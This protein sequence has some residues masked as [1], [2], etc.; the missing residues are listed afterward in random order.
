MR[1]RR[2]CGHGS[3]KQCDGVRILRTF[4]FQYKHI[5][6]FVIQWNPCCILKSYIDS[7]NIEYIEQA[8]RWGLVAVYYIFF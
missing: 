5:Q 7:T 6:S 3:V 4:T 2:A 8:A 1:I